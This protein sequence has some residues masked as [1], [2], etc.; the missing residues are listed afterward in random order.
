MRPKRGEELVL[1]ALLKRPHQALLLA[2]Q[3]RYWIPSPGPVMDVR[4]L[5]LVSPKHQKTVTGYGIPVQAKDSKIARALAIIPAA[6]HLLLDPW[7]S[8]ERKQGSLVSWAG[9][10]LAP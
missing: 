2:S 5:Q 3:C 9:L 1:P 8:L 6:N 10:L 7:Q 4:P